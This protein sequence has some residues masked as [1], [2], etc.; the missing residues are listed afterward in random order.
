MSNESESGEHLLKIM[1]VAVERLERDGE[2]SAFSAMID[3]HGQFEIVEI[4]CPEVSD[5]VDPLGDQMSS[6]RDDVLA[7]GA[8]A[9]AIVADVV[10]PQSVA[11]VFESAIMI[12]LEAKG[13]S[14]L[15]FFPYHM[16][17]GLIERLILR[18][19]VLRRE[20]RFEVPSAFAIEPK[21]F[22]D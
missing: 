12:R 21:V 3:A 19:P 1:D 17:K 10:R 6:L 14:S 4:S 11:G 8:V 20:S 15:V 22:C 13:D 18:A 5:F 9:C 16:P 7:R 2:L